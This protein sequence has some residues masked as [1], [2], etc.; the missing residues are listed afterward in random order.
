MSWTNP[1]QNVDGTP[2]DNP[3]R[4]EIDWGCTSSGQYDSTA[5]TAHPAT[6]LTITGL[7]DDGTCYFAGRAVN[8]L[9]AYSDYSK[10][11]V[12]TF[13]PGIAGTV[14][15]LSVTWQETP[16]TMAIAYLG[17]V[18]VDATGGNVS[19]SITVPAGSTFALV[20]LT[21]WDNNEGNLVS[22]CSLDSQS[23]TEIIDI[24]DSGDI[25]GRYMSWIKGFGTG[26]QTFALNYGGG[27]ARSEGGMI[28][29]EFYSGVDTTTPIVD[30]AHTGAVN[31]GALSIDLTSNDTG[32][33]FSIHA[34]RY[35][36]DSNA[37]NIVF[38]TGGTETEVYTNE[39]DN[40]QRVATSYGTYSS[41]GTKTTTMDNEYYSSLMGVVLAEASAASGASIPR[42]RLNTVA[43]KHM[44][45]R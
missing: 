28:Y 17:S 32:E 37:P 44:L 7:P 26:S 29:V 3:D 14:Q 5:M 10:E 45:G 36:A 20:K 24:A 41:S 33:Y 6:S 9:D 22:S 18:K 1:T 43:M 23:A 27:G 39:L 31:F 42:N 19:T 4:I 38:D 12:Q 34:Q 13:T 11:L 21:Y 30:S 2:Y 40:N 16:E 25:A 35:V 15:N 8:D